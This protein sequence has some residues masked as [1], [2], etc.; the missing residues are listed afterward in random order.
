MFALYLTSSAIVRFLIV[1]YPNI[2]E[3]VNDDIILQ[4]LE[5]INWLISILI[6]IGLML[7]F[8]YPGSVM[9]LNNPDADWNDNFNMTTVFIKGIIDFIPTNK[10]QNL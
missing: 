9:L 2:F 5:I 10:H 3:N 1:F 6:D 7:N 8:K 4:R